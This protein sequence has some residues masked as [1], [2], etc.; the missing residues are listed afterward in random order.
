MQIEWN[1]FLIAHSQIYRS[2]FETWKVLLL[3]KFNFERFKLCCFKLLLFS[4]AKQFRW[5]VEWKTFCGTRNLKKLSEWCK[6]RAGVVSWIFLLLL[7]FRSKWV[8]VV[9]GWMHSR[10]FTMDY[11]W[12][13]QSLTRLSRL[14]IAWNYME[15]NQVEINSFLNKV[16]LPSD[17]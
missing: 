7:C 6:V 16:Y 17:V 1:K 15:F 3:F 11:G 13:Y 10:K 14:S 8:R 12:F 5:F 4:C 2:R 9:W